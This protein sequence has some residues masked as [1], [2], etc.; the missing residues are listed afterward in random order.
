MLDEHCARMSENKGCRQEKERP[1]NLI[2]KPFYFCTV[3]TNFG[4]K[5]FIFSDFCPNLVTLN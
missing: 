3:G 2:I 4:G 5:S 1:R